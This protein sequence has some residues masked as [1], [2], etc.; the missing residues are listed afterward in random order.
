[1]SNGIEFHA[2]AGVTE[3]L[4]ELTYE[5]LPWNTHPIDLA[6][7]SQG[8]GP[9]AGPYMPVDF[10]SSPDMAGGSF[11][12]NITWF[13]GDNRTDY[14][15]SYAV[16]TLMQDNSVDFVANKGFVATMVQSGGAP[17]KSST[18]AQTDDVQTSG[19][20]S[21]PKGASGFFT[22]LATML[23]ART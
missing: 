8:W 16:L 1:M 17:A 23:K 11:G 12:L 10:Q 5:P 13:T 3:T 7:G 14:A 4:C 9:M 21:T 15:P 19:V 2:G 22:S 18:F 6:F 20:A